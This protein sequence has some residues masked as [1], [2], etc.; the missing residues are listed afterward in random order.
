MLL[1]LHK[2]NT[3]GLIVAIYCAFERVASD[4]LVSMWDVL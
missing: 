3:Q 1:F 2:D 4:F